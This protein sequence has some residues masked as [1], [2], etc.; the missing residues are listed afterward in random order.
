[1]SRRAAASYTA[2]GRLCL[3]ERSIP[4]HFGRGSGANGLKSAV[5][6]TDT[7][8]VAARIAP[9]AAPITCSFCH[10]AERS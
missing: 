10:V 6:A 2:L 8:A 7:I 5:R 3:N 9:G 4:G 1:M